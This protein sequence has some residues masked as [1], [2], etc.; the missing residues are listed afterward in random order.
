MVQAAKK[1]LKEE[2]DAINEKRTNLREQTRQMKSKNAGIGS[3][4]KIDDQ[5]RAQI[6]FTLPGLL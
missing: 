2:L 3:G 5:V 1:H 6:L 4:I